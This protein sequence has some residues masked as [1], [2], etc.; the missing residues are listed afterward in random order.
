MALAFNFRAFSR[1]FVKPPY[2][3]WALL[4]LYEYGTS[5]RFVSALLSPLADLETAGIL[6]IHSTAKSK[7]EKR[8]ARFAQR[9]KAP[10][11]SQG[12]VSAFVYSSII[13]A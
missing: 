10:R 12:I 13:R 7:I 11:F 1:C 6:Y 5:G 8:C 2:I 9:L 4:F 3:L